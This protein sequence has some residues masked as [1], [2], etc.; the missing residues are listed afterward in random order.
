[1][2]AKKLTVLL[3]CIEE[4][5]TDPEVAA[6][7]GEASCS[8]VVRRFAVATGFELHVGEPEDGADEVL[9]AFLQKTGRLA[10]LQGGER[11]ERRAEPMTRHEFTVALADLKR[12]AMR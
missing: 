11:L 7:M 12:K 10:G 9:R 1:M 3:A 2:P 4:P 8:P 6:V 5:G